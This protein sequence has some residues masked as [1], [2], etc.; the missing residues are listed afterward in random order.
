MPNNTL[1]ESL[2]RE[3]VLTLLL[4]GL[5]GAGTARS[6]DAGGLQLEAK[7]PLGSVRGR[8]DHLA[9]DLAR[10]RLF[11]AELGN[12]TVAVVD[13][14]RQQVIQ[15]LAGLSEPQGVGYVPSSDT[16]YVASAGDGTVRLFEGASLKPGTLIPL[17]DD[18]DNVRVEDAAHRVFVGYGSGALAVIDA[19][20]RARTATIALQGHPESF[21]LEEKGQRIFVNVPEA[22]EIAVVDRSS[23]RQMSS[24]P[25]QALR[26]N[27][28]MALE[29][30]RERMF[31]VFRHPAKLAAFNTGTG[32]L[33]A[34]L[35]TCGDADDVY[36]DTKRDRLYV[37]CGEG[38]VDVIET[39]PGG[40]R[41]VARISTSAGARTGLFAPELD[42]LFVAIRESVAQPAAIWVFRPEP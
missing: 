34:A 6:A 12:N 30:A 1:S 40:Y 25:T 15:T 17:G 38:V 28:P 31:V 13:L 36:V 11:V 2:M 42:R 3:A 32:A 33:S 9:L 4:G 24:W 35:E 16:L 8:I 21:R 26:A 22:H 29:E 20:S 23:N 5:L 10:R 19:M 7:I 27:F 18:A 39:R 41:S 37:I 14:Q